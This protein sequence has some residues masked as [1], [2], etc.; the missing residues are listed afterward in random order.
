MTIQAV[1]CVAIFAIAAA[2][3]PTQATAQQPQHYSHRQLRLLMAGAANTDDYQKLATYFHY[4]ELM[5]R[6]KARKVVDEYANDSGKYPMAT[7]TV[8]RAE[9]M[10]RAYDQYSSQANE[11]ARL[12]GRYD[13]MLTKLGVKPASESATIVS[14][15]SLLNASTGTLWCKSFR[16]GS[17]CKPGR[18]K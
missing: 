4:Q 9:V 3:R 18:S 13:E 2:L 1:T 8:T 16:T 12:A 10:A 14:I 6:T 7:K 15:N 11:N 17:E 5:C